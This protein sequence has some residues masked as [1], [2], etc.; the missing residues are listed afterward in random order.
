MADKKKA[1][2]AATSK[3]Q[4]KSVVANGST[5]IA[6]AGQTGNRIVTLQT[7]DGQSWGY[8]GKRGRVLAMLRN[9]KDGV[10]QH[11][12][13]PWHTRLS[14]SIHA[15]RQDGVRITTELEGEY[16]HARYR[17]A[18]GDCLILQAENREAVQ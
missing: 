8:S 1:P 4:P 7:A 9:A 18:M 3:G 5:P 16:R 11:D 17:L 14:G 2:D 6:H 15:M 13:L 12:T 10:T